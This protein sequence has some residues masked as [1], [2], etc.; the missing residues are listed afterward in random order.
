M[1]T[2]CIAT[3]KDLPEVGEFRVPAPCD[4][5]DSAYYTNDLEDAIVTCRDMWK[6]ICPDT[7]NLAI[8]LQTENYTFILCADR[9]YSQ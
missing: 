3:I 8:K 2:R 7:S 9:G 5:E 6:G 1:I 4:I